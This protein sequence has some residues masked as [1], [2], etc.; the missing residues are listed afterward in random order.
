MSE[1]T[2]IAEWE[3][4]G[5]ESLRVELHEF[6][7]TDIVGIRKWF[8]S[9]SGGMA[10]GKDGINLSLKHLARLAAAVNDAL[11]TARA[12]GKLPDGAE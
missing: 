4:N 7:G 9:S 8:P 3:L 10:P 5:R 1:P 2:I 12:Q 6:K 11:A